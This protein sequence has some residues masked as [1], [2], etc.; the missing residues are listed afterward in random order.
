MPQNNDDQE[1]MP[2]ITGNVL[3]NR[4]DALNW[5]ETIKRI[6]IWAQK[7][8]SR[9]ISICDAH[10]VVRASRDEKHQG[11]IANADMATP[12]GFPVAWM[13]RRQ[14]FRTQQ[15]INGPDL[16]QHLLA[17]AEQNGLSVYFYGTTEAT[18][19]SLESRL[20]TSYP[21]LKIVGCHAPPFRPLTREED[22]ADIERINAS[23]AHYVMTGLGCPKED[24]WMWE[25]KGKVLAVMLGIGAG[26]D[27]HAGTVARAPAWMREHGLEWLYRLA[28]EPRR[29]W[30][31]YFKYNTLFVLGA[32][33]QLLTT[34]KSPADKLASTTNKI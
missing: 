21:A 2:R 33:K 12:D 11:Y 8:E 4:I 23:G 29:L 9:Y 16:M 28:R 10:S 24:R 32:A 1:K 22:A 20:K 30:A 34:Q 17:H 7:R 5:E 13:L 15:R 14:G 3:G 26:I 18:L 27:F 19:S 31:R 25:H 6:G